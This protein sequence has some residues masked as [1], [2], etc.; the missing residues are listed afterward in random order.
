MYQ[1]HREPPANTANSPFSLLFPMA[2]DEPKELPSQASP[3]ANLDKDSL[4]GR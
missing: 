3:G 1:K 2:A 4:I